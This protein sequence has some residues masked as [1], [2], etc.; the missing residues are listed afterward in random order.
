MRLVGVAQASVELPGYYASR[1]V[2]KDCRF[3][4]TTRGKC[5]AWC[6]SRS[7]SVAWLRSRHKLA[8]T[9]GR[10]HET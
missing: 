2:T 1:Y 9:P 3:Y 8:A 10:Q 4:V 6:A 7:N 5:D